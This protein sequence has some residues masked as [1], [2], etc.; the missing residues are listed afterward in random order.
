M[1]LGF[2]KLISHTNPSEDA[3]SGMPYLLGW[4]NKANPLYLSLTLAG[5]LGAIL[6]TI[7]IHGQLDLPSWSEDDTGLKPGFLGEIFIG[8]SGAFIA[9]VFVPTEYLSGIN[10]GIKVFVTGL[11]GGYGGQ[12]ILNALLKKQLEL[13]ERADLAQRD[14]KQANA[15]KEQI[16]EGKD[17]LVL[18]N[19]QI[20][21]GLTEPELS[22]LQKK[23]Q[24]ADL[25]DKELIFYRASDARRAAQ[26][27]KASAF[28]LRSQRTIPIFKALVESDD[29]QPDYLAQLVYAYIESE[30]PLLADAISNLDRAIELR[31]SSIREDSWKYELYRAIARIKLAKQAG[32]NTNRASQGREEILR[33]LVAVDHN[34]GLEK[35]LREYESDGVEIPIKDWLTQNQ[36]WLRQQSKALALLNSIFPS[37]LIQLT[38]SAQ[39]SSITNSSQQSDAAITSVLT[40]TIPTTENLKE[41]TP[42]LPQVSAEAT[43]RVSGVPLQ[44]VKLIK[45]FEGC[46]LSAYPDPKTNGEPWT[47]GWGTTVYPDGK[48]VGKNDCISQVEADEYLAINLE[49]NFWDILQKKIPYWNEMHDDMRSALCSFAYNLGAYFY[50]DDGFHTITACLRDKRWHYV[51]KALMLYVNPGSNVEEG[52]RRRRSA[53]GDLWQQGL[54]KLEGTSPKPLQENARDNADLNREI[55]LNVQ[56]YS[57]LDSTTPNAQRMCFSST[58]AMALKY[59]RPEA[60]SGENA[61]D[62]YLATVLKYG[63]TTEPTAQVEALKSYGITAH[64]RQDL[65]FK[66]LDE[67]LAQGFP[68]AVG[69]NHHGSV[70]SPTGGHWC[71]VVGC[72]ADRNAYY[73]MD[74]YGEADLVNGGY[75]SNEDGR[76]ML[77]S[78]KNWGPRW[79]VDG[80]GTGWGVIFE[81]P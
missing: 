59:L 69:W 41:V 17:L 39:Q 53:E 29:N 26:R 75:T 15:E 47:I 63:D 80:K 50:G 21:N 62:T 9:Y 68:I 22:D 13:I 56:Y 27:S 23:I 6:H 73:F 51:P 33:D 77:Y 19:R 64:Y 61:D 71:L 18:V 55:K 4:L 35:T 74:P 76:Y 46:E 7:L 20:Q 10:S 34:K 12:L 5:T 66:D 70:D 57:Q 52:L 40:L 65:S 81:K 44:A 3:V 24:K 54:S 79:E 67:Q 28:R 36:D 32:E 16:A 43:K 25:E 58:C 31:G 2:A 78:K 42:K 37:P 8:I 60:L 30:P 72:K 49:K 14:A 48:K 38:P 11:V 1:A 45:E